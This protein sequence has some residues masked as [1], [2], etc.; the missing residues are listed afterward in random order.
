MRLG[1]DDRPRTAPVPSGETPAVALLGRGGVRHVRLRPRQH[2]FSYPTYFL[3]LPMRRLRVQADATLARNRPALVSFHD[4][5]HGDGRSDALA[6]LEDL[7]ERESIGGADGEIWLHCYPRV[8]GYVFK[9]VSFWYCHRSDGSLA[10][11]VVEVNNTFGER[12]CYL[13]TQDLAWGREVQATKAFHVSPF[14]KVEGRYRFRFLRTERDG[15]QHTLVS[16]DHDD[17]SGPLLRTSVWGRLEP[18]TPAAIRSVFLGMPL[19]TLGV[20]A[21]IHW[22]AL[23]LWIKRVPWH[24]KP[25]PPTAF[26]TR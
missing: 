23:R 9:P 26:T 8:L 10:A 5:D 3:M 25:S 11:I 12:H 15:A 6:W 22:H 2:A 20:I 4:C 24:R 19:M 17:A 18:L 13:L 21:R 7:L 16:I 14:C 1:S